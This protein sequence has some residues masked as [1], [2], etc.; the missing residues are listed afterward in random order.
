MN[1]EKEE[2]KKRNR[3]IDGMYFFCHYLIQIGLFEI[4]GNNLHICNLNFH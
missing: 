1:V 3:E 2:E 4:K